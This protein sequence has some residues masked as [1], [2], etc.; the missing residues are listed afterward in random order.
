MKKTLLFP[1][2]LFVIFSAAAQIGGTSTYQ[3]LTLQPN[4][5]IAALGGYGIANPD[6]DM[7]LAIQN[8]SLLNKEMNNQVTYNYVS[9]VAGIGAG[10]A[11]YTHHFD[12]IG[13]FATGIQYISYGDFTRTTATGESMGTFHAG[14]YNLHLSYARTYGPF[15]VGGAV[16]FIS[17]SLAEYNSY[18]M[19]VDASGTYYDRKNLITVSAVISNFGTQ[20]KTYREGNKEALPLNV[21]LGVSKK[22][23]KAP[24]R[25]SMIVNHLENPGG[26]MY[27][28]ANKPGLTKDLETGQTQLENINFAKKTLS[29]LT[30][31]GEIILSKNFYVGL[32]YNYLRRWEL[33][34]DDL[35]G[36]AGFSWGFGFKI[37]KFQ[38]AYGHTGYNVGYG[39]DHFSFIV[40]MSEFLK[41]K[42]AGQ[43]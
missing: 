34:L 24:L 17:S 2:W 21:Q 6:N 31:S 8:P 16:K 23:L 4:A 15:S 35:G 22:F 43:S 18:G 36:F 33:K 5:R 9:Y 32:G 27:Q 42:Q 39:T 29:H 28:N 3:F 37:S 26:L 7:N 13:T 19:A 40:Y 11:G 41:K 20:F 12:S 25:F 38:L 1:V 30:F 14:E 10:Y